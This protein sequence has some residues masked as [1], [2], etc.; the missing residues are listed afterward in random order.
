MAIQNNLNMN[1][2]N[3]LAKKKGKGLNLR[4]AL[5]ILVFILILL[6]VGYKYYEWQA[7]KNLSDLYNSSWKQEFKTVVNNIKTGDDF[8]QFQKDTFAAKDFTDSFTKNYSDLKGKLNLY[9]ESEEEYKNLVIQ[10]RDKYLALKSSSAFLFGPQGDFVK[11]VIDSQLKYYDD[12]LENANRN[13]TGSY[14]WS[15]LLS[16]WYDK[17]IVDAYEKKIGTTYTNIPKYFS[18]IST[19][20]SYTNSDFKFSHEDEIKKYFPGG[21]DSLQKYR[22]YLSTYY[23]V[24]Q[25]IVN[26]DYQSAAYKYTNISNNIASLTINFK[27]FFNAQADDQRINRDKE[28]V[29]VVSNQANLIKQFKKNGLGKY[30]LLPAI[31]KWK[32]DLV[33]CQMYDFKAVTVY[34]SVTSKYPTSK[35]F[36]DLLNELS[37]INPRTDFV[38]SS[39]DKSVVTFINDD[40]KIE[41]QCKDK[42]D[43]DTL[44]FPTKKS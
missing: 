28:I 17:G 11:K 39:F 8:F 38:D 40:K 7:V 26:G 31:N 29:D 33:L 44:L 19:I 3:N 15:G 12:E 20:Q 22:D 23:L 16:V 10:D 25:D 35:N 6:G 24:V 43:G 37:G 32:E 2:K 5:L 42:I 14:L 4:I 30:P 41:F 9:L 13:S 18:D 36:N 21:Y 34:N 27:D 1:S